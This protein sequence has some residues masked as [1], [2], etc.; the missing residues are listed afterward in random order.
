MFVILVVTFILVFFVWNTSLVSSW[1]VKSSER[2]IR[3]SRD[4]LNIW[5]KQTGWL[6]SRNSWWEVPDL[7]WDNG[8][9]RDLVGEKIFRMS[10]R[11]FSVKNGVL[12]NLA[13]FAGKHLCWNVFLVKL[14]TWRLASLKRES[15]CYLF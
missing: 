6:V 15:R 11:M 8:N 10:H 14:P 12:K 9:K 13:Y 1:V 3:K 2:I 4:Y 5:S 7:I